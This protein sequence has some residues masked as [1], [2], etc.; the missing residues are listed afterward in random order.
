ML[1]KETLIQK[2]KLENLS[3]G[4]KLEIIDKAADVVLDKVLL[5]I[6]NEL[7][8]EEAK[9][10]NELFES[11]EEEKIAQVL[12]KKFPNINDIFDEEIEKTKEDLG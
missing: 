7:T 4:E 12:Y 5:R 6:M 1:F 2:L 10:M 8:D 3:N 9:E 11:G